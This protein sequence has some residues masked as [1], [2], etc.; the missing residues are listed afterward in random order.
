MSQLLERERT[1]LLVIDVQER[2]NAAMADQSH[3]VRTEV[4]VEAC[5]GLEIPVLASEQYPQG[6]GPTVHL[7]AISLHYKTDA[8]RYLSST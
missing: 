3:L 8:H 1:A 6:L 5:R 7:L 2:I 4:M